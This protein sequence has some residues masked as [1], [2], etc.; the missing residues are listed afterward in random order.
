MRI[1][2]KNTGRGGRPREYDP[3][4]ALDAATALLREKGLANSSLD[5]IARSADMNRPSLHAAFGDKRDIYLKAAARF[6]EGLGERMAVA[7][8]A[9]RLLD[10]LNNAFACAL[11]TYLPGPGDAG[12]CFVICTAPAEAADPVIR[13]MLLEAVEGID[14]LFRARLTV[15]RDDGE[16]Q[17]NCP[18]EA[19]SQVLAASQHS[20][21]LRA[22]SGTSPEALRA[23]V[24]GIVGVVGNFLRR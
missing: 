23:Y 16:L 18:L 24:D 3:D 7:L 12:G 17:D 10:A 1:R 11:D 19:L 13:Q 8:S 9:P 5:E 14:E 15:A 21:A 22:R 6:G 4:E 2:T 20:L